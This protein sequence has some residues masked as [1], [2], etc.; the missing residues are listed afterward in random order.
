MLHREGLDAAGKIAIV[1]VTMPKIAD[2][3]RDQNRAVLQ[4]S[5]DLAR[6]QASE[7]LKRIRSWT[8]LDLSGPKLTKIVRSF[9]AVSDADAQVKFP[10]GETAV[11]A[12]KAIEAARSEWKEQYIGAENLPLIPRQA[13]ARE[14][15]RGGE[16]LVQ[17][18]ML[19][20]AGK[21][22]AALGADAVVFV[23][24][25]AA[26]THPREKTFIVRENRTDG[27]LQMAQ[28]LVLVDR[29]GRI[30]ADLGAP[31]NEKRARIR[32]LLPLYL[33]AGKDAVR[34]ENIDLGD[35]RK[36]IAQAFR[37]LVEETSADMAAL[38]KQ[39]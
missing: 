12:G 18:L 35:S 36:K 17:I 9:G 14:D 16:P 23:H 27:A 22:C 13:L 19:D 4:A 20:Q 28:S 31:E 6:E 11:S 2:V 37:A 21:L 1:T 24:M 26:I 29:S 3:T 7:N 8:I 38:L 32:D 33:G 10:D 34:R 30:I 39:E 15:G 25:H 5:V